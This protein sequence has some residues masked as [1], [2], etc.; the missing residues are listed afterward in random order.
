MRHAMTTWKVPALTDEHTSALKAW[1][2][3]CGVAHP[4]IKGIRCFMFNG[5]TEF[6]WLEAFDDYHDFQDLMNSIDDQCTAVMQAVMKH[7][8]PGTMRTG[9][10]LD[11]I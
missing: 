8:V 3:H 4:Q 9:I 6:V 1:Q 7:A 10:W 11:A 2:D 5:G